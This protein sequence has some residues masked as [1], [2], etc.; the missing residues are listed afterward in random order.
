MCDLL[1]RANINAANNQGETSLWLAALNGRAGVV[2][3]LCRNGADVD[4]DNI[5]GTTP[6]F[7]AAAWNHRDIAEILLK[8]EA[9]KEK[10]SHTG[11][12][13]YGVARDP[14]IQDLVVP[15]RFRE[16]LIASRSSSKATKNNKT[17]ST[18]KLDLMAL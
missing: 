8:Y 16:S 13:P 4:A 7:M 17:K 12:K 18:T 15:E 9:S 3:I 2:D 11:M 10:S 5:N 1:C 6:L 14:A